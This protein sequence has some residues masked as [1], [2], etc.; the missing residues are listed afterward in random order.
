MKILNAT[1]VARYLGIQRSRLSQMISDGRFDVKPITNTK[2]WASE[3]VTEWAE[4]NNHLLQDSYEKP[5]L[6]PKL[7][8]HYDK[9][10]RLLYIGVSLHLLSRIAQ[11]RSNSHWFDSIAKITIENFETSEQ[12]YEAEKKAIKKEKPLY[13][14]S[15]VK[16][17][18]Y[19]NKKLL[20]I[21]DL[22][23]IL[24]V[25]VGRIRCEILYGRFPIRP[26]AEKPFRWLRS[27]VEEM[28]SD[29]S[30]KKYIE[31]LRK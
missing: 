3:Y 11:H 6:S 12:V 20:G 28:I 16:N 5:K 26:I 21:F 22:S 27:D 19:R 14:I 17:T 18:S 10:D 15:S 2:Y 8:R 25:P 23:S 31:K 7:Y 9:E 24:A 29:K 4:K 30:L 1:Q 13:N